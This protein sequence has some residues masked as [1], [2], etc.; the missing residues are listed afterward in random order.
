MNTLKKFLPVYNT[1][2][3]SIN[4]KLMILFAV[5]IGAFV[6]IDTIT[7]KI[8]TFGPLTLSIGSVFFPILFLIT[9]VTTEVW[10]KK[11]SYMFIC[12]AVIAEA[13]ALVL[14]AIAILVPSAGFWSHQSAFSTIFTASTRVMLASM[15]TFFTTSMYD[16][17]IFDKI[18]DWT[19]NRHLWIR[20]NV[21]TIGSQILNSII[22]VTLAFAGTMPASILYNMIFAT[23]LVKI[24]FALIDTPFCYALVWWAKK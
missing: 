10:G 6:A 14:Y 16:V 15:F 7:L 19:K 24:L 13:V 17:W 8:I 2:K 12:M 22:F 1:E 11:I 3:K 23:I 9:D 21:S 18:R 20:N 4:P 5:F